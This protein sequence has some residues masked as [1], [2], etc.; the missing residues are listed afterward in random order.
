M[1]INDCGRAKALLKGRNSRFEHCLLVFGVVV[2]GVFGDVSELAGD[3][4]PL[5]NF[6][7]AIGRQ[8]FKFCLE[9]LKAFFCED[10]V[11]WQVLFSSG[12]LH[13]EG[14]GSIAVTDTGSDCVRH[15]N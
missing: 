14:S 3:L 15:R 13:P 5:G 9:L 7:P 11:S 4:N 10:Y 6:T 8:M 1:G 2:L 12:M